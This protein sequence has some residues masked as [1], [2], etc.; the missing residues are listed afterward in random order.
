MDRS[1]LG[2]LPR[3]SGVW[4]G[5]GE[6]GGK[7]L[8]PLSVCGGYASFPEERG[9]QGSVLVESGQVHRRFHALLRVIIQIKF[10][11]LTRKWYADKQI[12]NKDCSE[13]LKQLWDYF[14]I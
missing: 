7:A 2:S 13:I 3:I 8:C 11:Y 9:N 12:S 10:N 5:L 4:A 14:L 6:C 1:S